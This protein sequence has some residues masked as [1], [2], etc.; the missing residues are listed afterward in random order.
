VT[1][2]GV[3]W[4]RRRRCHLAK[5]DA[6]GKGAGGQGWGRGE[7]C[8]E[9]WIGRGVVERGELTSNQEQGGPGSAG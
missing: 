4:C 8:G 1:P 2:V 3:T 7:E 5:G 6:R 9:E